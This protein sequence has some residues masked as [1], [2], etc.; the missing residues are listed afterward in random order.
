MSYATIK[1]I[2]VLLALLA[3][4]GVFLWKVYQLLWVELRRGQPSDVFGQWGERIKAV[5]VYVAAQLR[6]FRFLIAGN[7]PLLHL[8][9]FSDPVADDRAGDH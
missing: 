8:L 3:A 7:G 1:S 2:L 4:G 9:G 5:V 6:L